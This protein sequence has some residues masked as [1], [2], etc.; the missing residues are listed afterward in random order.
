MIGSA[1]TPIA[2][3]APTPYIE[4]NNSAV[5]SVMVIAVTSGRSPASSTAE[6]DDDHGGRELNAA[7]LDDLLLDVVNADAG[8]CRPQDG[9]QQ[10][11]DDRALPADD[12]YH[13]RQKCNEQRYACPKVHC[14]FS[15]V[16]PAV[17]PSRPCKK[18]SGTAE[19]FW[20]GQQ[21]AVSRVQVAAGSRIVTI[22]S[23]YLRWRGYKHAL[24]ISNFGLVYSQGT[25]VMPPCAGAS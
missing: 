9:E 20:R 3:A 19:C 5:T 14:G 2:I 17:F 12:Q 11:H 18:K 15:P 6:H 25:P 21:R 4:E 22:A 7:G 24:Q 1:M 13:H 8:D 10:Q 16:S 23:Q